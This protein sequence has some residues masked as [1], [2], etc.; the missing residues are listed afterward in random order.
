MN[1]DGPTI[2]V[3]SSIKDSIYDT[4]C[5][6]QHDRIK[7]VISI[8]LSKICLDIP[9]FDPQWRSVPE[10]LIDELRDIVTNWLKT[11]ILYKN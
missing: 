10:E 8:T 1:R 9:D 5:D 2:L 6:I 11:K 4:M 3:Y 7:D